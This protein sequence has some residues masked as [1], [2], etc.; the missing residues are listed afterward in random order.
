[1]AQT[2]LNIKVQNIS[3]SKLPDTDFSQLKF[4]ETFSDHQLEM[5]Y[6]NGRWEQPEIKPYGK[7][8]VMPSMNVLHYGQG[9]FEGMKAFRYKEN[10]VNIFRLEKHCERFATSSRRMNIP[11]IDPG[12][13]I[14]SVKALVDL[15][16]GWVPGEK[17]K[18]LYIRPFI[19]GTDES[20]GVK[21][22]SNYRFMIITSPVG[23]YY[24]EGIK[25][26]SLTTMPEYVRAVS[27]GAGF[28][29]VPG[30]YAATLYPG[31][32]AQ[33]KGF[34]QVMWLDAIEHKYV[35]EVGTMNMF[36]LINDTLIT[37]P[38]GKSILAGVTRRSVI[39]LA[40]EWD[41]YL[42]ERRISID[43]LIDASKSGELKEAFGTGT[44][45]VI[46][47]VGLIHHKGTDIELDR[48]KMGP[49]AQKFYDEITGIQHGDIEDTHGWCNII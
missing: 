25:P 36:F 31:S 2:A 26:V 4:G 40:E 33:K 38:L 8:E 41:I 22:C 45:A 35:E 1:M 43:E 29:K 15:D 32:T 20:L 18:S 16:R 21:T 17:Y 14:E 19:M 44:A 48:K 9:V 27:G 13:F 42:E 12:V 28:A 11:E 3:K 46:S 24:S 23:N 6:Q 7:I 10:D 47:P 49:V 30:N 39:E 34:T 5:F 37:P